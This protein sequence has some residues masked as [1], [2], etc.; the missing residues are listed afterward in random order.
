MLKKSTISWTAKALV[1]KI[2]KGE[3]VFD[4][5]VQRGYVWDKDRKSLFIH[6]MLEEFPVPHF[7]AAKNEGKGYDMLDGKQRSNTVLSF[8]NNEFELSEATPETTLESGDVYELIG[9][10]FNDLPEELQDRINDFLLNIYY[11]DDITDDEIVDM[12][13]RL[14]NGKAMTAIELTRVKA[15]CMQQ[16]NEIARHDIFKLALTAKALERYTNEDIVIKSWA[17]LNIDN[18]SFETKD[19]RPLMESADITDEQIIELY[20]C[21]DRMLQTYE[22]IKK[23]GGKGAT[24]ITKRMLTRTH[25]IALIPLCKQSITDSITIEAFA[26]WITIFFSGEK[27]ASVNDEYNDA[28]TTGS[29]KRENVRKR[30][31]IIS[32]HYVEYFKTVAADRQAV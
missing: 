7:Y 1:S 28:A 22:F 6:T 20:D 11:F 24:K 13:F 19:I 16:I 17:M 31:D 14:N 5:A 2:N 23:H 12:F 10:R 25:F 3:V 29:A 27:S 8:I 4:N 21:Y 9:K 32:A 26:D 18:P 15:I 30:N